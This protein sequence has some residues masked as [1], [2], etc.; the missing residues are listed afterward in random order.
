LCFVVGLKVLTTAKI[1][2]VLWVV[3]K[4]FVLKTDGAGCSVKLT[5]TFTEL[6]ANRPNILIA[7]HAGTKIVQIDLKPISLLGTTFCCV[8]SP[9]YFTLNLP[10]LPTLISYLGYPLEPIITAAT[11]PSVWWQLAAVLFSK[12]SGRLSPPTPTPTASYCVG[13]TVFRHG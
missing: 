3:L 2:V 13:T 12:P 8:S 1:W 7:L 10:Q 5:T 4:C 9:Y 6:Q 11:A